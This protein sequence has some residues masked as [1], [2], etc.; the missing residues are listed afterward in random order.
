MFVNG[1][2]HDFNNIIQLISGVSFLLKGN[3]GQATE[4]D[5]S[6]LDDLS[7]KSDAL[8]A[9]LVN[10]S[11]SIEIETD[12]ID[13]NRSISGTLEIVQYLLGNRIV[14]KT[15]VQPG[16]PKI[17][18][19]PTQIEEIIINLCINAYDAMPSGGFLTVGSKVAE[20]KDVERYQLR[21]NTRY[22][23]LSVVDTGTG[24]PEEIQ[25]R[26]FDPFFSTKGEKGTGLGLATVQR[27]AESFG[28]AVK[29]ETEKS[30]G[31]S[32]FV[33]FP[34]KEKQNK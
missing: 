15:D 29:F 14:L 20:D 9:Q 28:G 21:K 22:L 33:F 24:I 25:K 6:L 31:T 3:N 27:I 18:A 7:K 1:L 26:I 11:R 10:F 17:I 4:K 2:A 8:T 13:L 12:E 30:K 5:I 23:K 34:V 16:I 19:N 32:F